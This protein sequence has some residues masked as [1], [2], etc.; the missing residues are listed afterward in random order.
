MIS[1]KMSHPI[2]AVPTLEA[3]APTL[4]QKETVDRPK[5]VPSASR[6]SERAAVTKPPAMTA[7]HETPEAFASL[8][9]EFWGL[10]L[11]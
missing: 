8:F 11:G 4:L 3:E 5:P 7:D 6:M 1:I 2:A 9:E 10:T